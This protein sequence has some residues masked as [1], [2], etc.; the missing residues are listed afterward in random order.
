MTSD[1][2]ELTAG[3]L[4][5]WVEKQIDK[6]P[7]GLKTTAKYGYIAR[8]TALF[9]GL[10]KAVQYGDFMAKAVLYDDLTQRKG[11]TKEQA[12]ARIT[13]EFV[14]YDRLPG[15]DR[16][17]LEN[18]GML[19]FYNYKIRI[20]KI[21]L[22]TIRNNPL[23]ALLVAAAPMPGGVGLPVEDN[24]ISKAVEG[25]LGYSIGPGMGIHGHMLNPWYNLVN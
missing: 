11:L 22:S 2:L 16:G 1:D 18:M 5:Q 12:L 15:R 14:N 13:E 7:A 24:L 20:S 4:T 3:N 25:S 6:L 21:A 10:Q 9:Q 19:W 23:H 8:D 17:Y